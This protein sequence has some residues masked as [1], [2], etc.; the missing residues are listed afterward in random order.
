MGMFSYFNL[1]KPASLLW[2]AFS[3]A[4]EAGEPE[5]STPPPQPVSQPPPP[6]PPHPFSE[7]TPR[8]VSGGSTSSGVSDLSGSSSLSDYTDSSLS[9]DNN[10]VED[11]NRF[12]GEKKI[13]EVADGS[14]KDGRKGHVEDKAAICSEDDTNLAEVIKSLVYG[15]DD[16]H[17]RPSKSLETNPRLSLPVDLPGLEFVPSPLMQDEIGR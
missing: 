13:V 7:P 17:G 14:S 2:K 6:L 12:A 1:R 11:N 8:K 4:R 5:R 15:K 9:E 16:I 10:S 3:P